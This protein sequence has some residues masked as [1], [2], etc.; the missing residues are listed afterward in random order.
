MPAA[1]SQHSTEQI[2]NIA[3]VGA[4]GA[5]KTTLIEALLAKAGAIHVAGE[6]SKGTTVTD[7]TA[8]EKRVGHSLESGVCHLEHNGV[9]M[10]LI[11]TPGNPDFIGRALS[12]LPGADTAA[13]VVNAGAG[14]E[15]VTRQVMSY[16][17]QHKMCRLI[18]VS[19]IDEHG[20]RLEQVLEDL[21]SEFGK[22]CL[23][24]NLP[25][26]SGSTVADC[27]FK[28][29][30][31]APDFS[32][33]E[34][35]H[36]EIVDQVVELDDE[37]MEIYLE[38]GADVSVEQLHRPFERALRRG[39]LIPVCFVSPQTGS[40]VN[41]LL[42]IFA[43]LMPSPLEGNP[44]VFLRGEGEGAE[45][46]T[47]KPEPNGHFLGH[48]FKINIDPYVGRMSIFRVHQGKV[49]AG[50]Q[51]FI[52]ERRK[53]FKVA[54]LY[55]LQGNQ[56]TEIPEAGPG[57]ICAVSK[58]DEL[59]FDA[60]IHSSHDEDQF[61]LR[62]VPLPEPMYGVALELTQRGDEKKLSDVLHKLTA[63]DPS[64]LIEVNPQANETVLRG[65]G[66]LHVR[67]VLER[68]REEF[69]LPLSTRPP[70]VPYRE[71]VT[72]SAEG[73][74]R[75]K[76]QT[77]GAGQFGEVYLRI[78]PLPR[79]SGFEFHDAVVGGTIP[80]Q[81]IPAVE[82]GV[83]QVLHEGA[84]GGFPLQDV[85]VTVY[86]GK[87]HAVDSKEIAFVAAGRKAFLDAISKANPIILEPITHLQITTPAD[88]VGDITGHLAGVRGRI[89]GSD[90]LRGNVI[91]ID[92]VAPLAEVL[93][94]QTTLKSL[95]GGRG[96]FS[97]TFDHYENVPP[98]VQKTL[99]EAYRPAEED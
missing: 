81:F 68:M 80:G 45:S 57:E 86:D 78:E 32:S 88:Y 36:T 97:M 48:V 49:R 24:I 38:Q 6:V 74:H 85:S 66:E 14:V 50:D 22:V 7:F 33:I 53:G 40:G 21:R 44:P 37:L 67:L 2:R 23:P 84:V 30:P 95:T 18:V 77:G 60:V 51:V 56:N 1:T 16:A 87:H 47:V 92:A 69:G 25:A 82:K 17:E 28:L 64:L 70:T 62:S 73:H 75:H 19:H 11:D 39:H 35:A 9:L 71:T 55:R 96:S 94:Y 29:S 93:E 65:M 72:R 31:E 61:H 63:E 27:F 99:A 41:Q 13:V 46:V 54:H 83:R 79:G 26:N 98:Q 4:N 34:T 15:M 76:K 89:N 59:F 20:P 58:V 43:T 90:A 5:G 8:L 52:G 42:N 12:V 3:F 91:R 10:N